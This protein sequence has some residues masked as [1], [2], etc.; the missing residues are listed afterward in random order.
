MCNKH[1]KV[2]TA[3]SLAQSIGSHS[4]TANYL[5]AQAAVEMLSYASFFLFV[6]VVAVAVF[7]QI[8]TQELSR[9]ETAYAQEVAY[10]F[11]NQIRTAYIAGNGFEERVTIPKD[12][13]N[14]PYTLSISRNQNPTG[15][16]TGF[17]YV[18]WQGPNG[19]RSFSASTITSN[20]NAAISPGFIFYSSP[21]MITINA[22]RNLPINI[23]NNNGGIIFR[24]G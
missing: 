12:I 16:E 4:A 7:F 15:T 21:Y 9:A 1:N 11:A 20:Y 18:E 10:G 19:P 2:R 23:S 14:K 13:L 3:F 17:V 6:F 8:Q 5:K 22:S 24:Q